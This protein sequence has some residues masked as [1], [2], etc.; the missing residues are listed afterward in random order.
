MVLGERQPLRTLRGSDR[1]GTTRVHSSGWSSRAV[2][3]KSGQL[4][5]GTPRLACISQH[6]AF[7]ATNVWGCALS[8]LA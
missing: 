7:P 2:P 4:Q 6:T 5:V 8:S 3:M 1:G